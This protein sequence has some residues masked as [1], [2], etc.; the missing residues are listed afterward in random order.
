MMDEKSGN[1]TKCGCHYSRHLNTRKYFKHYTKKITRTIQ[2]LKDNF[3]KATAKVASY[4]HL[5]LNLE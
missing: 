1:C 3:E 4:N 2:E 5:I